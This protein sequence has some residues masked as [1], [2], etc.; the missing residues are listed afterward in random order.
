VSAIRQV[1]ESLTIFISAT[2]QVAFERLRSR[3]LACEKQFA[4]LNSWLPA[5]N[6]RLLTA[7]DADVS[8]ILREL[9]DHF[10]TGAKLLGNWARCVDSAQRLG[11]SKK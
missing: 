4:E 5:F 8:K 11:G 10:S 3:A 7:K 2:R 1:R 6:E 9:A